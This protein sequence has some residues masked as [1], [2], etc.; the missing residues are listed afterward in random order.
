MKTQ[1]YLPQGTQLFSC[2]GLIKEADTASQGNLPQIYLRRDEP[3]QGTRHRASHTPTLC[4][5]AECPLAPPSALDWAP[6]GRNKKRSFYRGVGIW[7]NTEKCVEFQRVKKNEQNQDGAR[8]KDRTA[9]G[10]PSTGVPGFGGSE[11]G[12]SGVG[13]PRQWGAPGQGLRRVLRAM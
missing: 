12:V 6:K 8:R 10:R 13:T 1:N 11:P 2:D 4:F 9:E 5:Q 3:M 7:L